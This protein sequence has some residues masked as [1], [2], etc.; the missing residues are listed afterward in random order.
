MHRS[1]KTEEIVSIDSLQ[2]TYEEQW[3]VAGLSGFADDDQEFQ[4]ATL[5]LKQAKQ[6]PMKIRAAS[7][8]LALSKLPP[9]I[10]G[11]SA[12]S[13]AMKR[14]EA[15]RIYPAEYRKCA[16][17]MRSSARR[18]R[19]NEDLTDTRAW[20]STQAKLIKMF[21]TKAPDDWKFEMVF[22]F[23]IPSAK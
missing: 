18:E 19:A 2:K 16:K 4:L 23:P 17:Q 13:Q 12:K 10:E 9:A 14:T 3:I 1:F 20:A 8:T 5:A 21:G 6:P 11:D 22:T 15:V 7:K